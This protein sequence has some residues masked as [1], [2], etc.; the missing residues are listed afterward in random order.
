MDRGMG[1]G[2]NR[3]KDAYQKICRPR[4]SEKWRDGGG[5]EENRWRGMTCG[6]LKGKL[7]GLWRPSR[8]VR[9]GE[10]LGREMQVTR[11][12]GRGN[13]ECGK[14]GILSRD[15]GGGGGRRCW[16]W[17]WRK[18]SSKGKIDGLWKGLQG[19]GSV[20]PSRGGWRDGDREIGGGG[21]GRKVCGGG[22]GWWCGDLAAA[23]AAA[24]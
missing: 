24:A 6:G 21:V 14:I 10:N 16:S 17:G 18:K 11:E 4:K 2:N 3:G 12:T 8:G 20:M 22:K 5:G 13:S 23:A 9:G 1:N 15:G 19:G 7:M